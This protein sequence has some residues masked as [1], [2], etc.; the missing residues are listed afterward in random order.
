ME[1]SLV[2]IVTPCY[3]TGAYI[4]RL[5][6]SVLEQTYPNIEMFVVNDGSTDNSADVISSYVERF[7]ARGYSL[8]LVNQENQ[9]QSVAINRG[10]Q[11]I[12]GKYFV[13]PDSDD[14]YASPD[15]IERMVTVF[16][17]TGD[18]Y[19]LVRTQ[20][21]LLEDETLRIIGCNGKN[22]DADCDK[23]QLFEDCLFC[24]N[25]FFFCP[26]AYM[27][28]FEKMKAC[29]PLSIYTQKDAG[30][31]WQLMLPLLYNYKCYTIQEPL[32]NVVVRLASHSRGQ[33]KKF[34]DVIKKYTAYENTI[35]ETIKHI[36][37]MPKHECDNYLLEIKRK[38][39][40]ERLMQSFVYR[41][42]AAFNK[43]YSELSSIQGI[44][45]G[46][47][48]LKLLLA[49]PFVVKCAFYIRRQLTR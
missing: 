29:M 44:N 37:G 12:K 16:E 11:L 47:R 46:V 32:Y 21:N 49:F 9:G 25:G 41:E 35:V 7:K 31:N 5:L 34:K 26:G 3:N 43:Y 13:W 1:K 22:A 19:G 2:S 28:N 6:D 40:K 10:L 36:N 38:Y 48:T 23:L 24:K 20:E 18:E 27:A 30:Q 45:T 42:K 17:R 39:C 4:H 14:F 33:Y 8:T 15:A